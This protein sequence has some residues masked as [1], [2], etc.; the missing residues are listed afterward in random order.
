MAQTFKEKATVSTVFASAIQEYKAALLAAPWW[1]D[2]Y[3]KL[4]LAQKAASQYDDAIASLNLYLLTQPADAR[5]AQDEIYKLEANKQA[6]ADQKAAEERRKWE[7][8]NSPQAIAAQEQKK[9]DDWLRSLNG[10]RFFN[11]D[12]T[13]WSWSYV[14]RGNQIVQTITG[15]NG[16]NGGVLNGNITGKT[17]SIGGIDY[18]ISD[19]GSSITWVSNFNGGKTGIIPR[20]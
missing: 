2:A 14:I 16:S 8:E 20:Q 11:S 3:E 6:A 9:Y 7:E 5:D 1:A 12:G 13:G 19:S 15:P 4:A 18:T 10:A 17:F